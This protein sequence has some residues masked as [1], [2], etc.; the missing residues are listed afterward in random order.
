MPT[1]RARTR[2]TVAFIGLDGLRQFHKLLKALETEQQE[3]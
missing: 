2:K 3:Q 1:V